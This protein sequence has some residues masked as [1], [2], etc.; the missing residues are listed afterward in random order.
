MRG[1]GIR[2]YENAKNPQLEGED[3]GS[4]VM[5][6]NHKGGK[7]EQGISEQLKYLSGRRFDS[8]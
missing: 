5:E 3:P 7:G 6:D 1:T 2:G 4:E 8:T